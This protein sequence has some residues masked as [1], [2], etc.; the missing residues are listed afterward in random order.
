MPTICELKIELKQKGIK[1]ITG[2]NKTG[3]QALLSGKKPEPKKEAPPET[4][5]PKP[6]T[7]APM[8]QI[9]YSEPS[10]IPK[11]EPKPKKLTKQMKFYE[12]HKQ[13]IDSFMKSTKPVL[14]GKLNKIESLMKN[15]GTEA[16]RKQATMQYEIIMAAIMMKK[17]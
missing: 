6:F 2:L 14:T 7:P 17:K 16:E 5:K 10:K 8:K 11:K 4:P 13:R 12:D 1:G 3:L 9:K 15:A